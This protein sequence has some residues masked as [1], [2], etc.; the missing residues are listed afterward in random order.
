MQRLTLLQLSSK[1]LVEQGWFKIASL[2]ETISNRNKSV[3]RCVYAAGFFL[4]V[5]H[6][7]R[8]AC[9]GGFCS[10]AKR[11]ITRHFL[12]AKGGLVLLEFKKQLK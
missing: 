7:L 6:T 10:S 5:L 9:H 3:K 1:N 12:D 8:H 2:A 11:D 4:A